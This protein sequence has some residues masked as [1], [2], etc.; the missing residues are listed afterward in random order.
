MK[1]IMVS[2]FLFSFMSIAEDL[3]L[4]TPEYN[5]TGCPTGTA[6]AAL[7]PDQKSLSILFDQFVV[8]AG[9]PAYSRIGRKNC[10]IAIPVHVP[11][12]MSISVFQIDY[13][14]FNSL[15]F[16]ANSIFNVEYFF[17][18]SRG[19]DY[20]KQWNGPLINDYLLRNTLSASSVIWSP[21]G[22]DVILR[23]NTRMTVNNTSRVEEAMST[24]D[25]TDINAGLVFNLRWKDCSQ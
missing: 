9:G 5:G 10:N 18:G 21:C 8:N 11:Q 4:G 7:S 14:G 20:S 25:S 15:P 3:Y 2:I 19:P 22:E 12:G 16:G 23:A 13:R 24:V 17:A 6:A 1:T